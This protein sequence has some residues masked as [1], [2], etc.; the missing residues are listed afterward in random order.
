[1]WVER[2]RPVIEETTPPSS[3]RTASLRR[4]R[5]R[6]RNRV[7]EVGLGGRLDSTNVVRPLVSAVT[8][9][10]LDHQNTWGTASTDSG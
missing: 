9:I 10:E 4:L 8:K 7:I 1:M 5:A 3:S 6:G 2:L